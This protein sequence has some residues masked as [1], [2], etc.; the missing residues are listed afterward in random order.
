MNHLLSTDG[1]FDHPVTKITVAAALAVLAATP[2]AT[3][4][5]GR[6]GRMS[7]ATR[8]DVWRRYVT[9]LW[10]APIV[11]GGILLCPLSAMI[12]LTAVSLLCFREFSRATGLFRHR[13]LSA[14]AA[15]GILALGFASVDHWYNFFTAIPPLT[16][17][18]LAAAAVLEDHPQGYLQRVSLATVGFLVFGA[19]LGH[20]TY[21]ANAIEYRPILCMLLLCTQ[22]SDVAAYICGKSFGRRHIFPNTSP[23]KTLGGHLGALVLITPLAALLVSMIYEDR[24]ALSL[25]AIAFGLLIAVGAQLGDLMLGSIKRDLGVKDL[26]A[27]LPGHG[28]FTDRFNSLVL[29]APASFH[30]VGYV[31]GFGL[32]RSIRVLTHP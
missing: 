25:F 7:E 31:V 10:L 2:L 29:V 24:S 14:I 16:I 13:R 6:M 9:W 3:L 17:T 32:E 8:R 19:G 11:L 5:L 15:A 22:L 20:L 23:N 1:A 30:Y 12:I 21:I 18:L 4:L 27:T 28:G 26:A